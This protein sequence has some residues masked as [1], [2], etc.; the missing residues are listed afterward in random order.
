M[1]NEVPYT[2]MK[3]TEMCN[4]PVDKDESGW[5]HVEWQPI[6]QGSTQFLLGYLAFRHDVSHE[7]LVR[8]LISFYR[9]VASVY[10]RELQ[11]CCLYSLEAA[12]PS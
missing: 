1:L 7:E 5:Y 3:L 8:A 4:L 6:L 2:V 10:H 12:S 11:Q 9:N